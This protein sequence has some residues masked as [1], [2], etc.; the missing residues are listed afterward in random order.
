MTCCIIL[1]VT[2]LLILNYAV[3]RTVYIYA[4]RIIQYH[5]VLGYIHILFY[6]YFFIFVLDWDAGDIKT[7]HTEHWPPLPQGHVDQ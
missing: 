6:L 1:P 4:N 7:G 3:R 5:P 2:C